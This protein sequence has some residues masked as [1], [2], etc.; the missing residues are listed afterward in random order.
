MDGHKSE[1]SLSFEK[2]EETFPEGYIL[3][4]A[5]G[6]SPHEK[7]RFPRRTHLR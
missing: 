4:K 5:I 1:G 2:I 3:E 6:G 7:L